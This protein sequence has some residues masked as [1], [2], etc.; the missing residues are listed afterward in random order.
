MKFRDPRFIG[1]RF[2]MLVVE[3]FVPS[4]SKWKRVRVSC[5]CDCGNTIEIDKFNLLRDSG[6]RSCGCTPRHSTITTE[7]HTKLLKTSHHTNGEKFLDQ[8]NDFARRFSPRGEPSDCTVTLSRELTKRRPIVYTLVIRCAV[9]DQF[10][11]VTECTVKKCF[12]RM[13]KILQTRGRLM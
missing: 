5:R 4:T 10:I 8:A 13:S 12:A 1:K 3:S 2:G 7:E 9:D 6:R 11:T